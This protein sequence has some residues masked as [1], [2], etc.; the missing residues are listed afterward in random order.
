MLNI[1]PQYL[2]CTTSNAGSNNQSAN[3]SLNAMAQN[4]LKDLFKTVKSFT[5][6]RVEGDLIYEIVP[7]PF[8]LPKS[9]SD[10]KS[11]TKWEKFAEEKGIKNKKR[12]RMVFSEKFSK[13]VPRFGS[14]SEQ[15]LILQGGVVEVEG[16]ISKMV[17]EKKK[18][19]E[20]NKKNS[21][22]NK[23]REKERLRADY[24]LKNKK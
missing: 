20:K 21:E 9:L 15:N 2:T 10:E 12:S 13:W 1:Y 7:T 22:N 24:N 16:S 18:R 6:T 17:N 11:K 14:K 5:S 8:I 3:A 19:V 4:M 23:K